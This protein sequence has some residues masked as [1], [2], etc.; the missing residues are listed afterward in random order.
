MTCSPPLYAVFG[1]PIAHS[2]SP[3]LHQS[4][5]QAEGVA[6]FYVPIRCLPEELDAK[7]TAFQLIGG[8]GINLTRPLKE[9]VLAGLVG[10][11]DWVEQSRAANTIK[12]TTAGWVGDNTDCEGLYRLLPRAMGTA[13]DALVLGAGGAAR[14]SAAV[15]RRSGYRIVGAARHPELCDWADEVLHWQDRLDSG[16]WQVVVQ[17]TPIGQMG[18][19]EEERW[20]LPRPGGH[21]VEWVYRPR[22]TSFTV[23]ARNRGAS[24]IDGLTLL[25]EQAALAWTLWFGVQGPRQVMWEAVAP[26]F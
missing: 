5:F 24:V 2:L 16:Q 20:P 13:R 18:E 3:T 17:A 14:A 1:N 19:A 12:W 15:L 25:V 8:A 26:W 6:A 11:S 10:R 21:A 7:L 23:N 4:A 22:E 9:Q